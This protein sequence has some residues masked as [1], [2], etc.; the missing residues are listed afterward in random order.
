VGES[1][2]DDSLSLLMQGDPTCVGS[3]SSPGA[4]S[5]DGRISPKPAETSIASTTGCRR[6]ELMKR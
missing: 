2:T 3:K 5:S 6:A 4:A 1:Q